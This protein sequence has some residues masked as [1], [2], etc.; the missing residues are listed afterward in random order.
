MTLPFERKRAVVNTREFLLRLCSPPLANGYKGVKR[1]IREE[2]RRLLRHYPH[3]GNMERGDLWDD[4]RSPEC[5]YVTG[6]VTRHCTLTPLALTDEE[7]EA[8]HWAIGDAAD[9]SAP[10]ETTLRSLLER[11]NFTL[12][13]P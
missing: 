6:N 3:P 12:R 5:P 10:P 8:I 13:Q 11:T 9:I 7:R 2:A 4:G 1:E